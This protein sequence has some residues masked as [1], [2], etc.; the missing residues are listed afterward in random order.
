LFSSLKKPKNTLMR[1]SIKFV[2]DGEIVEVK[3]SETLPPTTTVLNYL[4][5]LP[6]HKGVKEG[7]AEG[8]CGACTVVITELDGR[9]DLT[10]KAIDSCLVFLP[11]IHGKQLITVENLALRINNELELHPVQKA[12][13]NHDGSQCG[14]C[15]PGIVMSMFAL[16]KTHKNPTREIVEDALVGN[17]CRCTGYRPIVDAAIEVC[18]ANDND[19]FTK[20]KEQVIQQLME[21]HESTELIE[22]KTGKQHYLKPF[23]ITDTLKLREQNP[24]AMFVCGGTDA[25]LLQTKKNILLQK[26]IDISGL[27]EL[28]LIIEDHSRIVIGSGTSLEDVREYC[29]TRLPALAGILKVFGSLQIRN[30]ATMGGNVM[31]ASPIGDTLPLLIALGAQVRLLGN[32]KQREMLLEDFITAYRKTD[33]QPDEILA[34]VMIPTPGKDAI[35]KSY[36]I[37]KRVDLDISTVSACFKLSLSRD[38]T[39]KKI[40]IVYGGMADHPIRVSIIEKY[41]IGKEWARKTVEEA[42]GLFE[43]E[44][45]PITDARASAEARMIMAKNLLMK[46]WFES[47]EKV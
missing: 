32:H 9:G 46:F 8:D 40:D 3:F 19:Q 7:C 41:F 43:S 14:Y 22:I 11:M 21:L 6:R 18:S 26:V 38:N 24:D 17:L 15:T 33:I 28:S 5:S 39:V 2:L 42:I 27:D 25:A 47:G 1:Q 23:S 36:K 12:M 4:R 31:S 35:V 30:I 20:E 29:N 16:Y 45:R 13:V 10:Y 44:F 37:S 34:L